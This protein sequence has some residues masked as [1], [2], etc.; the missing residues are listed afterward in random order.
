MSGIDEEIS[1]ENDGFQVPGST[2]ALDCERGQAGNTS[3]LVVRDL[4][5]GET[6]KETRH[7]MS[8]ISCK[9]FKSGEHSSSFLGREN[10]IKSV[11]ISD[12]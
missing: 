7:P 11:A 4:N 10:I 3:F 5:G 9:A 2:P 12:P 1:N 8:T 6:K